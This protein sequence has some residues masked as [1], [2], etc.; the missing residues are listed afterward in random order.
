MGGA[1]LLAADV[2]AGA[3]A[4]RRSDAGVVGSAGGEPGIA[5]VAV[6]LGLVSEPGSGSG[7]PPVGRVDEA[8]AAMTNAAVPATAAMAAEVESVRNP[9][10]ETSEVNVWDES[11]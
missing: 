7:P 9:G 4:V 5:V 8:P 1:A 2:A 10:T 11:D 3:R 6:L